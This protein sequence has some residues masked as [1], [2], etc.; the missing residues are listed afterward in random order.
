MKEQ[1]NTIITDQEYSDSATQRTIID[2]V[3]VESGEFIDA[4]SMLDSMTEAELTTLKELQNLAK[5][6]GEYKYVCAVCGQP[7]RLDSRH[8]ASRRFN[9]YFFSHYT[10]SEDCPLK[11]SSDAID[12]VQSTIKFYGRFKESELHK[13]MCEKLMKVLSSDNRFNKIESYPTINIYGEN[14]HWHKPDVAASFY[15]NQL[16]FETL[17]YN[18]FLSSIVDKNSF[19]R[20]ANSFLMWIFPHFSF[21]NQTMYEKDVYYT[22][23]RNIFVFDSERYYQSENDNDK[24]KPKK[25]IF[26]EKGYLYA[27][28]ESLKRGRLMLNCYWQIPI[29]EEKE[30][31][32][33]WHHKLIDIEELTFDAIRKDV[34]FHNSDYDFKEVADPFKRELIENWERAKEERWSKIFQ[35]IQERKEHYEQT[36]K[37][38]QTSD[39]DREILSKVYAGEIVPE[40]FAIEDKY[41]FKVEETTII[42][43]QY[44]KAFPFRNGVSI[45]INKRGKRGLI[46]LRNERILDIKFNKLFWSDEE[47][48][49]ILVGSEKVQPY[50]YDIYYTTGEKIV[51]YGIKS[52]KRVNSNYIYV[53]YSTEKFGI[54][55]DKGKV[56]I[57]P[58]YDKIIPKGED[59]YILTYAG[60]TR[61]ISSHIED[62]ETK[63]ISELSP[64]KIIVER[65]L[66]YGIVD[67]KGNVL[68]PYE[69]ANIERLSDSYIYLKKKEGRYYHYG[70]MDSSFNLIIPFSSEKIVPS[71]NGCFVKG[72]ELYDSNLSRLLRGYESIEL[73]PDGNYI[74]CKKVESGWYKYTSKYGLANNEGNIIF[75]C[76][77]SIKEIDDK[78]NS[79]YFTK[80]L[81]NG[82]KIKSCFGVFALFDSDGTILTEKE[83]SCMEELPNGN[84]LV[85]LDNKIGIINKDGEHI[86]ECLYDNLDLTHTGDIKIINTTID[87]I[88]QKSRYINQ[89]AL[90]DSNGVYLTDFKYDEIERVANGL[91]IA[92]SKNIRFI[93]NQTGKMVYTLPN[94]SNIT[95]LN[96]TALLL[97]TPNY[98]TCNL[99]GILNFE[100]I[101]IVPAN[102]SHI[103]LL[104]NG[105]FKVTRHNYSGNLFGIY[106]PEGTIIAECKYKSIKTDNKGNIQPEYSELQDGLLAACLLDKFSLVNTNKEPVTD[107]LYDSLTIFDDN[108]FLVVIGRQKG[109]I[110]KKGQ[111]VIPM[112]ELDIIKCINKEWIIV[113]TYGN[114][115]LLKAYGSLTIPP[116]FSEIMRL[117]NNRWKVEKRTYNSVLYGIYND[118]GEVVCECNYKELITDANGDVIPSYSPLNESILSAKMFDKYAL[119]SVDKTI[120][121]EYKYDKITLTSNNYYIVESDNKCGVIDSNGNEILPMNDYRVKTIVDLFHFIVERGNKQYLIN[122]DGL[123]LTNK[124]YTN[125][126]S[127]GNGFYLGKDYLFIHYNQRKDINDLINDEGQ[128]VFTTGNRIELDENQY[129]VI[130]TT[131]ALENTIVCRFSGKY[132]ICNKKDDILLSDFIYDSVEQLNDS[133]FIVGK[134][135]K[136]GLADIYG[137]IILPIEY[138]SDFEVYSIGVIKFCKIIGYDYRYG[139]CN[140]TGEIIAEA[141]HTFIR[142]NSPGH[143]KLFYKEG[144]EQKSKFLNIKENKEFTIGQIYEGIINGIQEYGVF[145]K[146]PRVG[147]GLLHVK[148]IKKSGK[149][150]NAFAKGDKI[151]V[152]VFKIRED[153]KVEFE[154]LN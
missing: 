22:H 106:S 40:P 5:K 13:D 67:D 60:K 115:G 30:I 12:P 153:G 119:A 151:K 1:H 39:K 133:L 43:P 127:L 97:E 35:G 25:P 94:G 11:T 59:K 23:R 134:D 14:I 62:I 41:G 15:G 92:T 142:E 70:V 31:K 19:Y 113:G 9:S 90:S 3:D 32:V 79:S 152:K 131:I 45:V 53:R 74:L 91:Y 80:S 117:P 111:I 136:F 50:Y 54:M 56:L 95:P 139:L 130:S 8:Y 17:I 103:K 145:I 26:A 57:E 149:D 107:Y 150:V 144:L 99:Y 96:E 52:I 108:Y 135:D 132:A 78:G 138:S 102:F 137:K 34:F 73:C 122:K 98:G 46:N 29:I 27:Q 140:S 81:N 86:V 36:T 64:G 124:G 42:K 104:P 48:H 55:S 114:I 44:A 66:C 16:V 116:A 75:P 47:N 76:I 2:L 77:A 93:L 4:N 61:T 37:K 69:Y 143:F 141:V 147:L 85:R 88:C 123:L 84:L 51:D 21:D 128:I 7:L 72:G 126:T 87:N 110:N 10:N 49:N 146:V 38:K 20:M 71:P 18:T 154:L 83:Y 148:Q 112:T 24:S 58:L 125:I 28:E 109:L 68:L 63:F 6:S 118:E 129:P 89:Y 65:L 33:E 82:K 121:T 120:I 101:L 100:G 105:N